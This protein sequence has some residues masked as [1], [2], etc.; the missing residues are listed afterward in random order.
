MRTEQRIDLVGESVRPILALL[1]PQ[2]DV[3]RAEAEPIA[4]VR[5]GEPKRKKKRRKARD[6]ERKPAEQSLAEPTVVEPVE[7]ET[8]C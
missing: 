4:E 2:P 5:V 6:S 1:S 7:V 8:I 3:T